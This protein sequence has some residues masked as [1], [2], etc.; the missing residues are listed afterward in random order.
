[1]IY[2][3]KISVRS[4]VF[5]ALCCA[6]T[7]ALSV[8]SIPI[9]PVP[10]TLATLAVYMAGAFMGPMYGA[11]SQILYLILVLVGVPCTSKLIGGFSVF[12]GPTAGFLVAYVPTAFLV[13]LLY[14]YFKKK[15]TTQR[16]RIFSLIAA[17][18]LG[19]VVCYVFGLI[20]YMIYSGVDIRNAFLVCVLPFLI[21]DG[22][23]IAVVTLVVPKAEKAIDV[24]F[25]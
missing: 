4:I 19:T 9:Q 15:S 20:W 22:L 2:L 7:C 3:Q 24:D 23:K 13:G 16:G 18:V 14:G 25:C 8:V 21:G 1:M 10:I 17:L 6:L 5:C 12:T 11:I